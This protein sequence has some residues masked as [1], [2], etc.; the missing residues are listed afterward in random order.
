[1]NRKICALVAA[2]VVCLTLASCGKNKA[3]EGKML[4]A[5]KTAGCSFQCPDSWEVIEKKGILHV[6][7]PADK[8]K[9]NITAFSFDHGLDGEKELTSKEYWENEYVKQYADT[10]NAPE[11]VKLSDTTLSGFDAVNAKYTVSAGKEKFSCETILCVYGDKVY[12]LTMTQGAKNESNKEGYNN[13][14]DELEE[15][16]KTF[17]IGG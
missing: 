11:N 5:D 3:E 14:S 12:T 13:H 15:I 8:T 1:M 17:I 9:A 2:G 16:R 10:F 6:I 4:V 7:N